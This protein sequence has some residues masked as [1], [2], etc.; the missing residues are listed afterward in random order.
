[1]NLTYRSTNFQL[2]QQVTL[3]QYTLVH[4]NYHSLNY[5]RQRQLIFFFKRSIFY[6]FITKTASFLQ[7]Q[8]KTI[9]IQQIV[10]TSKKSN[11]HC[12]SIK[13]FRVKWSMNQY[14][15]TTLDSPFLSFFLHSEHKF[16]INFKR[17]A[18]THTSSTGTKKFPNQNYNFQARSIEPKNPKIE[19]GWKAYETDKAK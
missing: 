7:D 18:H 12:R 3:H 5:F 2:H 9:Y 1:M 19:C 15:R 13:N 6:I 10:H 8:C 16:D 17:R 4:P 11:Q 14:L